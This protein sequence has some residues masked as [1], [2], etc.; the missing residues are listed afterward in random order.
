[1]DDAT[2]RISIAGIAILSAIIYF[3]WGAIRPLIWLV[4]MGLNIAYFLLNL[5]GP[6]FHDWELH[7]MI[8]IVIFVFLGFSRN[9]LFKIDD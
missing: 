1:M 9:K 7:L 3:L 8:S 5:I 6:I 4:L 2:I